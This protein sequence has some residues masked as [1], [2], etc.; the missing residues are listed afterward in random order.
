MSDVRELRP[1]RSGVRT[2]VTCQ[3]SHEVSV[4]PHTPQTREQRRLDARAIAKA[5]RL[6]GF[7]LLKRIEP[8]GPVPRPPCPVNLA[9]IRVIL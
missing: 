8:R 4:R 6:Y 3:V 5:V 1:P 2:T 7:K 9:V